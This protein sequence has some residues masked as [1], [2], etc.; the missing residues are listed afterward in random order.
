MATH[1][2]QRNQ[3]IQLTESIGVAVGTSTEKFSEFDSLQVKG[4][5]PD[6]MLTI[7]R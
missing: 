2:D 6:I 3:I 1:N 7:S 5:F 4:T